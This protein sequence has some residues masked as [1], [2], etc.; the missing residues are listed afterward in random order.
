MLGPMIMKV[1]GLVDECHKILL[2]I[3]CV[4]G[5]SFMTH[6]GY[7]PGDDIRLTFPCVM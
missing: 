1:M 3:E 6:L 2:A 5:F 7:D 4:M